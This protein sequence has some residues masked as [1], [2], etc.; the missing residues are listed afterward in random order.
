MKLFAEIIDL[1]ITSLY[2]LMIALFNT[3]NIDL[4][5]KVISFIIFTGYNLHRWYIM[6][7]NH[8]NAKKDKKP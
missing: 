5:Y 2:A 6:H 8:K 3:E 1:K 4:T 7:D